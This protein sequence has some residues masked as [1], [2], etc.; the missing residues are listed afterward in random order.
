MS[1]EQIINHLR[2]YQ[3][4]W[5][6]SSELSKELGISK[7]SINKCLSRMR[8]HNEVKEKTVKVM[9]RGKLGSSISKEV[10]FYSYKRV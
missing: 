3:P 7:P 1:Q 8:K 5:F 9:F 2:K 10:L 4:K 6:N